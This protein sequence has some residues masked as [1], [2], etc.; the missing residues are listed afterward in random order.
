MIKMEDKFSKWHGIERGDIDWSPK[1]DESK[2]TD[3]GICAV[4][5]GREVYRF[6]YKK[7]KSM[8]VNPNNCMVACQTCA[9]LCPFQAISFVRKDETT[10]DRVQTIV[11][12]FNIMEKARSE[13]K[14]RE[15]ELD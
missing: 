4:T 12:K 10:R 5:C 3:C 15:E 9:N 7:R 14:Q 2:C 6:D 8:V 1:I 11:N 13:L